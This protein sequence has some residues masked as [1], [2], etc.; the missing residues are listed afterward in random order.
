MV[1]NRDYSGDAMTGLESIV[2]RAQRHAEKRVPVSHVRWARYY[3]LSA[4]HF[5][6]AGASEKA[7]KAFQLHARHLELARAT[8]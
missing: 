1:C 2:D 7:H 5:N 8:R 3:R 6:R 4:H